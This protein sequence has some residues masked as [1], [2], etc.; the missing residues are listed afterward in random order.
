MTITELLTAIES[1]WESCGPWI[2][3]SKLNADSIKV[4]A[5]FRKLVNDPRAARAQRTKLCQINTYMIAL[6]KVSYVLWNDLP[7][8]ATVHFGDGGNGLKITDKEE[9]DELK[10]A[11]GVK[12]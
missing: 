3:D 8:S 4:K 12:V 10:R 5:L 11:L 9:I 2:H 1:H 7:L 6:D